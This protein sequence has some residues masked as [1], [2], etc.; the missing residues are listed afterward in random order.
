MQPIHDVLLLLVVLTNFWV[1]GTTRL[2]ATIRATAVQGALLAAL[3]I[4]LYPGFSPHILGLAA[5][6]FVVKAVFLPYLLSR[7]IREAAVRREIESIDPALTIFN[8]RAMSEYLGRFRVMFQ[9]SSVVNGSL[10]AFG[11][12]LSCI[13]LAAVTSHAVARRRKE[14]G[15]RMALGA[16]SGQV[17]RLVLKEGVALVV[18]GSVLG[19]LGAT[20]LARAVPSAGRSRASRIPG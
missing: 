11:L 17:L 10:G 1:L 14:I 16:R 12:I 4:A 20:A 5:G 2:S 6:T 13:G 9:W 8:A 19:F 15:I 3:P 7:A 18:V